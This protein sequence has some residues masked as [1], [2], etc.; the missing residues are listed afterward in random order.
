MGVP[1]AGYLSG[2]RFTKRRL[3]SAILYDRANRVIHEDAVSHPYLDEDSSLDAP[4]QTTE[5]RVSLLSN[6]PISAEVLSEMPVLSMASCSG[7]RFWRRSK[8]SM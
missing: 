2:W 5:N 1:G 7:K 3:V 8:A 4:H 6:F